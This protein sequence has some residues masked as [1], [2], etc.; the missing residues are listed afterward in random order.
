MVLGR[1][2]SYV[3]WS[4]FV[5]LV[6]ELVSI[7]HSYSL[8]TVP[9]LGSAGPIPM[10]EAAGAGTLQGYF[11]GTR[12]HARTHAHAHLRLLF[13]PPYFRTPIHNI[14]SRYTLSLLGSAGP[15]VAAVVGAVPLPRG[16]WR[17]R[18]PTIYGLVTL[19]LLGSDGPDGGNSCSWH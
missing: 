13:T 16:H 9:W 11:A 7:N 8:V 19:P 2:S 1:R 14:Y 5:G 10:A 4:G 12:T 17:T 18:T 15:Q 3:R 6:P